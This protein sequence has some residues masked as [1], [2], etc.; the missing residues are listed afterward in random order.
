MRVVNDEA[1][2]A[3]QLKSLVSILDTDAPILNTSIKMTARPAPPCASL[4]PAAVLR[5][6]R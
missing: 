2:G 6:C 3:Y 4:R 5:A 1:L